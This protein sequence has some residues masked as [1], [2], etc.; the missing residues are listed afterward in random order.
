MKHRL[1]SSVF[2]LSLLASVPAQAQLF[3]P[4]DEEVAAQ[5]AH[6]DGQDNQIRAN[7]AALQ[8][9]QGQETQNQAQTQAQLRSLTERV[10]SLTDSLARATGANEELSHQL[11]LTN[12]KME[13]Q[14]RDFSYRLCVISAQQLGA[15]PNGLNCAAAGSQSAALRP[16]APQALT[17]GA[18]LPPITPNSNPNGVT[19][20]NL[21]RAPGTLGTLSA[22]AAVGGGDRQYDAAMNLL[23]RAQFAEASAAF[24]A[25][26]D[27]HP[28]D[29]E[30]SP[31]ALYWVGNIAY[32]Q[33]DYA[34]AARVF[35][36]QIKKYPKAPRGADS[37]L[38]MGQALVAQGKKSDG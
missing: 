37:M 20:N 30:L 33:Q 35:A 4:S 38:K 18:T 32:T 19:N 31:Q 25:Y 24:R 12:Q 21:G 16:A 6:E 27:S 34:G 7:A 15:D 1:L 10:Q 22:P 29:N 28:D 11:T 8:Q 13:Q 36:E 2:A 26:A 23:A 14:Q 5:K 17:P 9:L 3:G